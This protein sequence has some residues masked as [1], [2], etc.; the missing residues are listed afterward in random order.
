WGY[1]ATLAAGGVAQGYSDAPT[2]TSAGTTAP[3]YLPHDPVLGVQVIS[4]ITRA[5]V[6]KGYWTAVTTDDPTIYANFPLSSGNRLDLLTYVHYAGAVPD[7]P[8]NGPFIGYD[9]SASR[10]FYARA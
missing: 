10:G 6:D 7:L 2:C 4:F 1:V 9:Q 3:C 5:M 8:A